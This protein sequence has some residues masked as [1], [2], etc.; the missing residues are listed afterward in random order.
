MVSSSYLFVT[1][2]L[3][4]PSVWTS[5]LM[6]GSKM[7]HLDTADDIISMGKAVDQNAWYQRINIGDKCKEQRIRL[8][9]RS[10]RVETICI[11]HTLPAQ[12]YVGAER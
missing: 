12:L 5:G 4:F 3:T 2:D 1:H 9:E 8:T 10:Q 7:Q 11:C 6:P